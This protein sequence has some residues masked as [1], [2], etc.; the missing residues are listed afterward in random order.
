MSSHNNMSPVVVHVFLFL[1]CVFASVQYSQAQ[2]VKAPSFAFRSLYSFGDSF[3]DP[4][5]NNYIP[6]YAK[7]NFPPYGRNFPGRIATGRFSNGLLVP[8][9][10]AYYLGVKG[11]QRP[12]LGP[13]IDLEDPVTARAI[14]IVEQ[15]NYFKKYKVKLQKKVGRKKAQEQIKKAL[16]YVSAGSD[17]FAFTYFQGGRRALTPPEYEQFLL[18]RIRSFLQGLVD[19]GARKIAVNGLPPLGC[20]SEPAQVSRLCECYSERFQRFAQGSTGPTAA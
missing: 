14:Q 4:G 1:V 9:F 19:Q 16:F 11:Y 12:Y 13:N 20:N 2:R 5:N 8:D 10:L 15:F 7:S 18:A 3:V 6:T 17:D